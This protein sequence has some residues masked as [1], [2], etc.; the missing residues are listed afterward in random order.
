MMLQEQGALQGL[1]H[2]TGGHMSQ[3][4]G[5]A[6]CHNTTLVYT[7]LLPACRTALASMLHSSMVWSNKL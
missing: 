3:R 7:Y 1:Q 6:L 4:A 2:R 5:W